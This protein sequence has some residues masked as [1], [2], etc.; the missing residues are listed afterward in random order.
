MMNKYSAFIYSFIVI[1]FFSLQLSAA[2]KNIDTQQINPHP[3]VTLDTWQVHSGD[4][5]LDKVLNDKT[6]KWTEETVNHEWWEKSLVKWYKKIIT[7]PHELAGKDVLFSVNADP[8]SPVYVDGKKLFKATE[9]GGEGI[10]GANVRE[11]QKFTIAVRVQ[12][13]SYCGRFYHAELIGMPLGYAAFFKAKSKIAINISGVSVKKWKRKLYTDEDVAKLNYDDSGWSEINTD[14]DHWEGEGKQAWYRLSL[15]LPKQI[16][17]FDVQGRALRMSFY[18]DDRGVLYVNG[19]KKIEST[20]KRFSVII[21]NSAD[22]DKP[23]QLA[24]KVI[25]NGGPGSL[26]RVTLITE[27]EY[28]LKDEVK[29]TRLRLERLNRYFKSRPNPDVEIIGDM[30]RFLVKALDKKKIA[31]QLELINNKLTQI[32]SKLTNAP[33][34]LIPPYLQSAEKSGIT[35]MWETVYPAYGRVEY[36]RSGQL[37]EKMYEEAVPKRVHSLTLVGL[38]PDQKYDYRVV[39]EDI[40]SPKAA[41]KTKPDHNRPFKFIVYGDNR[42]VPPMHA[43][44]AKRI[45]KEKADFVINVGDVVGSGANLPAW[46]DEYFLPI[47]YYSSLT[48]TYISIGNHEYGGYWDTRLVPPFEK[49][50]RHPVCSVGS[51][52]YYFSFEFANSRFIFLDPNKDEDSEDSGGNVIRPSTQQYDWL[53]QELIKAD[54]ENVWTFVILHEP[55]YSECW[56]GGYYDGEAPLRKYLV[57]LLEKHNVTIVFSG[58]THDYERGLPHPPYDSKTGKGNNITYVITGGGGAPLDN[59]KYYEWEQIDL[60]DHKA[61]TDNDDYDG[62]KYYLYNYVVVEIDGKTLKYRAVKVNGDGTNGGVFDSFT[63]HR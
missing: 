59:H 45:A 14:T 61:T 2:Q 8:S 29:N 27:D 26:G 49:Y 30:T 10:L 23:L 24:L 18:T 62:G 28:R 52:Q 35:I 3:V 34:F 63:F 39:C 16:N 5:L 22:I 58:H 51:N 32:E 46:I 20:D 4:L 25:N 54:R 44:V 41:F 48:P 55:P 43:N 60:P 50:V 11:G 21:S 40:A 31:P 57:P 37:S 19:V 7:I 42:T 1:L 56:S 6:V 17:G 9:G 33:A 13:R 38:N 47:R 36:G 15:K 53:E 12:N